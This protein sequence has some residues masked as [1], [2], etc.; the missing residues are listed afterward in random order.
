MSR[1]LEEARETRE[2]KRR[3]RLVKCLEYELA[4]RLQMNGVELQGFALKF[5]DVECLMTLKADIGGVRHVSF[6]GSDTPI[7]CILKAQNMAN[8]D[9]LRWREDR[10]KHSGD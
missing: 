3:N 2:T 8:N 7:N 5:D 10:Y 6:V 9:R 1:Q 4:G